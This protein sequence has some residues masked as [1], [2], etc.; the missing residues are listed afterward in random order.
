MLKNIILLNLL[1]FHSLF[2]LT[3]DTNAE[4]YSSNEPINIKVSDMDIYDKNWI[5]IYP[6]HLN[7]D[8]ENVVAWQWLTNQKD[9]E[10]TFQA[11]PEG[12][13][14]A[15][16]FYKNSFTT[17]IKKAFTVVPSSEPFLALEDR[18]NHVEEN[19]PIK[20]DYDL[21]TQRHNQQDWIGIYPIGSDTAWENVI[22][23]AW[24]PHSYP[25][26]ITFK[27]L[28]TGE[29]SARLFYNNSFKIE[30]EIHF[31]VGKVGGS[32]S[33][34]T[35]QF[36]NQ[37]IK[38][39]FSEMS[40]HPE[41]WIAI[42]KKGDSN[43]W[44]N[45]LAWSYTNGLKS[46]D[47]FLLSEK[48]LPVGEYEL[49]SFF[50]NSYT[51]QSVFPFTVINDSFFQDALNDVNNEAFKKTFN[52]DAS[53]VYISTSHRDNIHY[54]KYPGL[55][56]FNAEDKNNPK[57]IAHTA[58]VFNWNITSDAALKEIVISENEKFIVLD[59]GKISDFPHI[60]R[61]HVLNAE[62][63][64][65]V[66]H[67]DVQVLGGGLKSMEKLDGLDIFTYN[68]ENASAFYTIKKHFY[69][70]NHGKI[71]ELDIFAG[72]FVGNDEFLHITDENQVSNGTYIV[73]YFKTTTD[74][75][76]CERNKPFEMHL[77][78]YDISNLPNVRLLRTEVTPLEQEGC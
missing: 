10:L 63:L 44:E 64:E 25:S 9:M 23:W 7:N 17:E 69:L 49:R 46:S 42:Y 41:D 39:S 65:E 27:G 76:N 20:I 72:D 2:A 35:K 59:N 36:A 33:T 74:F 45:V 30:Q 26:S 58:N 77:H 15:R 66:S 50:K 75:D 3:L 55:T 29:Y 4:E 62:S 21:K 56:L 13:Y 16:V 53:R 57:L 48:G 34:A 54:N 40:G 67:L 14:E 38:V 52:Q 28:A 70:D 19:K 78:H 71:T 68:A 8:W 1:L 43:D 5:G 31:S 24:I 22:E 73:K 47:D 51:T 11:L 18:S 32:V 6:R 61:L 60:N 37:P 12:D